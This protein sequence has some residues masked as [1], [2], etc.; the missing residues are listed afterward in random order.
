MLN[1]TCEYIGVFKKEDGKTWKENP[2]ESNN[3]SEWVFWK[4][5]IA[6]VF[7]DFLKIIFKNPVP[8]QNWVY[9]RSVNKPYF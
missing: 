3:F 4:E 7:R 1:K 8:T 2:T 6:P 9:F 5:Y